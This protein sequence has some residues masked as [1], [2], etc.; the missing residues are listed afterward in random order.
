MGETILKMTGIEKWFPGVHALKACQFDLK[1]GEV[2]ALIGENGAGKSTLMKILTGVYSKD[3]GT[4][5]Y[6]GREV[7]FTNPKDAQD[8]GISIIH[9]ELNLMPHLTAAQ[10]IYIGREA[11]LARCV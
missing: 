4:V 9:Q 7:Q 1:S 10:N 5:E 2:H 6:M 3:D 11:T 8:L